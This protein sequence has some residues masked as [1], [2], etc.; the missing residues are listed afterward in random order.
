MMT[1]QQYFELKMGIKLQGPDL[2]CVWVGSRDKRNVV[3]MEVT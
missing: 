3:Y 1:V 2:P